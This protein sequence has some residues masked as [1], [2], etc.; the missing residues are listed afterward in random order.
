MPFTIIEALSSHFPPN[1]HQRHSCG[2][3]GF[4]GRAQ[5][6]PDSKTVLFFSIYLN[7]IKMHH[8]VSNQISAFKVDNLR[9]CVPSIS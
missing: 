7:N 6:D 9:V 5:T 3:H 8:L 2:F 1:L 4:H